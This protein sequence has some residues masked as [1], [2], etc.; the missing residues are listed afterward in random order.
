MDLSPRRTLVAAANAVWNGAGDGVGARVRIRLAVAIGLAVT[1]G[2]IVMEIPIGQ[3][4][5]Y[6]VDVKN[7]GC[8]NA[9]GFGSESKPYC[10]LRYVSTIAAPGDTFLVKSGR[11]GDGPETFRRSGTATAPITYRAVGDVVIGLFDD[12]RDELFQPTSTAHVYTLPWTNPVTPRRMHQTY[13]DPIVVDDPAN[14]TIFTMKQEDGPLAL[15]AV[16]DDTTLAAQEGTWRYDATTARLYVHPY[17]HRRPSTAGTDIV[18][19]LSGGALEVD[20]GTQYNTFDGFRVPY[21]GVE[22]TL[23]V[24]GRNNRF[25]NLTIQGTPWST[26]GD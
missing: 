26:A 17:G 18:V 19:G 22:T 16:T 21:A 5:V 1:M 8:S 10:T 20:G 9:P 6:Y 3:S 7:P 14:P 2:V 4:A 23:I 13:F 24:F 11:Y 12:V 15:S 25:L